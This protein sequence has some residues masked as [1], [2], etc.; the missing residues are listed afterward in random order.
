[1][2][3]SYCGRYLPELIKYGTTANGKLVFIAI[4]FIKG[5]EIRRRAPSQA[6]MRAA[7]E[8]LTAIHS[9]G[10]LHG[11]IHGGNILVGEGGV[12]FIDFGFSEAVTNQADCSKELNQLKTI[13]QKECISTVTQ[14]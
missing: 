4:E 13:W 3:E 5:S 14:S 9:S 7:E 12:R 8:G 2:R 10:L 11:D 6:E 1:M